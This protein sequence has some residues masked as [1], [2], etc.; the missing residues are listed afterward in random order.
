MVLGDFRRV[1]QRNWLFKR[2]L[3]KIQK[4][5]PTLAASAFH[6]EGPTDKKCLDYQAHTSISVRC[7]SLEEHSNMVLKYASIRGFQV[8]TCE[9]GDSFVSQH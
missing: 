9:I 8:S 2:F 7:H 1:S 6:H 5:T 3:K 4:H